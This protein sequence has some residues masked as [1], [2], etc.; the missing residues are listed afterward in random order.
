[1]KFSIKLL[2]V[3]VITSMVAVSCDD[4]L[5][6]N[7]NP[8]NPPSAP[9][10]GFMTRT[11]IE[12]ARNTSRVGGTTAFFT[13][14]FASPNQDGSSDTHAAVSYGFW[15]NL[16]FVLGDLKDMVELAEEQTSP[17]YVGIG[18]ILQAYNLSLL[19]N[20]Y[21]DV[22][23]SEALTGA[24]LQ[25]A[26]DSSE[27][28][29]QVIFGLLDNAITNLASPTSTFSPGVDD[30]F[31]AGNRDAWTRT[32]YALRARFLNHLSKTPQY[33]R[34]AVLAAVDNA[35]QNSNQDFQKFFFAEAPGTRNPWYNV[36]LANAGLNLG[37]WLSEHFVNHLNGT[38][39]PGIIDP[40][41][42]RITNPATDATSPFFGQ[43]VGTRNGAG[44]GADPASGVRAV[45]KVGSWYASGPTAPLEVST[46]VEMKFIEAEAAFTV[47]VAR[48]F[49]AYETGVKAHMAKLGVTQA[50]IDDYWANPEVSSVVDFSLERIMKEKYVAMFLN[51]EGWNDARRFNYGYTGF[52]LPANH[53]PDLGGQFLRRI[54]YPDSEF[55]RNLSSL[56]PRTLLDRV[57]WDVP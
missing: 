12:S 54:R 56:P 52:Q 53:N 39:Y 10:E 29:Y 30:F 49:A 9:L 8:N 42:S 17:H 24:P 6:V 14:H 4:F 44:R 20:M 40:R 45:L 1:M 18:Q 57:F 21:G 13:Q 5:D 38:I 7:T 2:L 22:P 3:M 34:T 25:P 55:Q 48:S 28:L 33:N 43:Y 36:A 32:A 35:F 51:P 11:T 50:E 19:V 46:F 16:Y 31:F 47:D 23:F 15:S 26:Y 37:G 41:I 27:D